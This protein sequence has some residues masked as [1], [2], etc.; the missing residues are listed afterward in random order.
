MSLIIPVSHLSVKKRSSIK[1]ACSILK[2][3]TSYSEAS[4]ITVMIINKEKEYWIVPI[5]IWIK[6]YKEFPARDLPRIS[7][8]F[9]GSLLTKVTD[10][11]GYRDQDVAMARALK[12]LR[13][14]RSVFL[15]LPTG[16]GKTACSTYLTTSLGY[17]TLVLCHLSTVGHE[18][19]PSEYGK[20]TDCI[21]QVVKGKELDPKA[22]VY[23]MGVLKAD[24]MPS[25]VFKDIG[26]II[27]DEAHIATVTAC[28]KVFL[29]VRPMYLIGLSATPEDRSD[30]LHKLFEP[31]F[32]PPE[33]W[34]KREE[35]KEFT[36]IK[37]KTSY[38]PKI[39][40]ITVQG[41]STI[42]WNT[43]INSLANNPERQKEIGDL[44]LEH[45]NERIMILSNRK[46]E[47][48][49]IHKYLL[50]KGEDSEI[51]IGTKKKWKKDCRVLVAGMKKAGVG[52]NDPTL[53]MLIIATDS[54]NV[55]QYEGRIR[56]NNNIIYDVVDNYS[57]F[58]SHWRIRESWYL[59][60]GGTIT[61][62]YCKRDSLL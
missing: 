22:D 20:F 26:V 19:W 39:E 43:V 32:G 40:Y 35:I 11:K 55:K 58:E 41:R 3:E 31:F 7:S 36:V 62:R 54:K 23:I 61:T 50:G 37:Y 59:E 56:T 38:K 51:L 46:E 1:E 10:P 47:C 34:I 12:T 2:E 29:K 45:P 13:E 16:F 49:G 4:Y 24:S 28:T 9:K 30:G 27:Y 14:K 60:R 17:K 53:T 25:S 8:T 42:N 48:E 52:F 18:Q 44:A 57:S 6:V 33:E 15:N 5:R 21:V